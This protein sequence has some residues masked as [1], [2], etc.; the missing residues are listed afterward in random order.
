M[1]MDGDAPEMTAAAIIVAT[2]VVVY[3]TWVERR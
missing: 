3:R 2:L 1:G